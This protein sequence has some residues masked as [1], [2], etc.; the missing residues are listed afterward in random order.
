MVPYRNSPRL[1]NR[2]W[3]AE[4][5]TWRRERRFDDALANMPAAHWNAIKWQGDTSSPCWEMDRQQGD[6]AG[7][8][9]PLAVLL[10]EQCFGRVASGSADQLWV[11]WGHH[12]APPWLGDT[13][14]AAALGKAGDSVPGTALL[15]SPAQGSRRGSGVSFLTPDQQQRN[16]S[17]STHSQAGQRGASLLHGTRQA[18]CK[19]WDLAK[20]VLG[21]Y[22]EFTKC[23]PEKNRYLNLKKHGLHGQSET[24]KLDCILGKNSSGKEL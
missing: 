23:L 11:T 1:Q 6:V 12:E 22:H 13:R 20:T 15:L 19:S 16:T 7:Q 9:M 18:T 2:Y 24:P 14:T 8:E 10:S 3:R 21:S 17:S 5:V 4:K